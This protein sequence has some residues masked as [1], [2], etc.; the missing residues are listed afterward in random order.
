MWALSV[1]GGAGIKMTHFDERSGVVPCVTPWGSWSQTIEEVFVEVKVKS[2]TR[3]K[4]IKCELT[5]RSI[6]LKVYGEEIIKVSGRALL[7][8]IIM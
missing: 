5:S 3:S 6:N 4:D 2:G 8:V 1:G 7:H